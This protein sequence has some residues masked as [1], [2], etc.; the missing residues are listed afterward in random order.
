MSEREWERA[1]EGI[2]IKIIISNP[3][4]K[5]LLLSSCLS[6]HFPPGPLIIQNIP[7]NLFPEPS[8]EKPLTFS[9]FFH[10]NQLNL[11]LAKPFNFPSS[12]SATPSDHS[13]SLIIKVQNFS[14]KDQTILKGLGNW[15]KRLFSSYELWEKESWEHVY[16]NQVWYCSSL[17]KYIYIYI[18]T[19]VSPKTYFSL[20][21]PFFLLEIM[22]VWQNADICLSPRHWRA[23]IELSEKKKIKKK[24]PSL[25]YRT[26]CIIIIFVTFNVCKDS[27]WLFVKTESLKRVLI[28]ASEPV[29]L[30]FLV[31]WE[32]Q[33]LWVIEWACRDLYRRRLHKVVW[34]MTQVECC[35]QFGAHYGSGTMIMCT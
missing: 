14:G 12:Y 26:V 21:G 8:A 24:K 1:R 11:Y 16:T 20:Y 35:L 32:N 23:R 34:M 5:N 10:L 33:A 22:W 31:S 17:V 25:S 19:C 18:H 4:F 15:G 29:I 30:M 28:G 3:L 27:W 7:P 13:L 2:L 6:L 9:P